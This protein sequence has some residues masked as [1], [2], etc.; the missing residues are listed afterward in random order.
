MLQ[1]SDQLTQTL[2]FKNK[3]IQLTGNCPDTDSNQATSTSLIASSL[4]FVTVKSV[5]PTVF[6]DVHSDDSSLTQEGSD[7][8]KVSCPLTKTLVHSD[9]ALLGRQNN[10]QS[11]QDSK[12]TTEEPAI[13]TKMKDDNQPHTRSSIEK[14]KRDVEDEESSS[15]SGKE[16]DSRRERI[17]TSEAQTKQSADVVPTSKEEHV[18]EVSSDN[19]A[20]SRVLALLPVTTQESSDHLASDSIQSDKPK[21]RT[22][23]VARKNDISN[24]SSRLVSL[25][26]TAKAMQEH[27]ESSKH[28]SESQAT[29]NTEDIE[30]MNLNSSA[31]QKQKI[32]PER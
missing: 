4:P 14:N 28:F 2:D 12:E 30:M 22:G 23:E 10:L 1:S 24:S 31:D 3:N 6:D 18:E 8:E 19:V 5:E 15:S 26:A 32:F 27:Q 21:V 16:I 25:S 17:I 29:P 11:Q 9:A 7:P 13:T 20:T